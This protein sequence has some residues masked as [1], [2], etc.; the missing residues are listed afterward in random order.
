LYVRLGALLCVLLIVS[1]GSDAKEADRSDQSTLP[2]AVC[3]QSDTWTRPTLDQQRERIWTLARYAGRDEAS[4][5]ATFD[6]PVFTWEGGNSEMFDSWPLHGLW[7]A[8]DQRVEDPCA[9]GYEVAQG[10]YV[11]VFLLTYRAREVVLRGSMYEV[12]VEPGERGFQH[13]EFTN[14]L[15]PSG[16]PPVAYSINQP[17]VDLARHVA[18][19]VIGSNRSGAS[20]QIGDHNRAEQETQKE[21]SCQERLH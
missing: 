4:F 16:G 12:T 7:S 14:A 13:I 6:E 10:R 18:V 5:H 3:E 11:D 9:Q 19:T 2:F 1:C 17:I 8:Q 21:A 20:S 15:Y